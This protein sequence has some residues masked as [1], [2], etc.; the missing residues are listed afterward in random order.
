M[1]NGTQAVMVRDRVASPSTIAACLSSERDLQTAWAGGAAGV[2]DDQSCSRHMH[3]HQPP[4]VRQR[5]ASR[6]TGV[7][8]ESPSVTRG[9]S[10]EIAN[11]VV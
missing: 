3:L 9:N 1:L 5:A 10:M 4:E 6:F 2:R 8:V 11:G 7:A